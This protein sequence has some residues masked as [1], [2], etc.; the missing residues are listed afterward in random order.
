MENV[1]KE[2]P[3]AK[4]LLAIAAGETIQ[5]DQ[6]NPEGWK[7]LR[8][9]D[10]LEAMSAGFDFN[11]P[12]YRIKPRTITVGKYQVAEPMKVAPAIGTRYFYLDSTAENGVMT[13]NWSNY[14]YEQK[15]LK[16]GM[17][18]LNRED[19]KLAAKA[20]SELLLGAP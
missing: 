12:L 2:H 18:W 10:V 13:D 6:R 9:Q 1:K 8:P 3:Q 20:F 4:W 7:A 16:S 14:V 5:C 19:A 15:A 11:T 17:C